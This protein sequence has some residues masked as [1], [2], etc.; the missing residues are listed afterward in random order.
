[1]RTSASP[2]TSPAPAYSSDTQVNR[3]SYTAAR[4]GTDG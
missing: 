3:S 1:M 2:P 4:A